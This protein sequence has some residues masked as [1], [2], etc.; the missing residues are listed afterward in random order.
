[1]AYWDVSRGWRLRAALGAAGSRTACEA[2]ASSRG[3][4]DA[5]TRAGSDA[6]ARA[7]ALLAGPAADARLLAGPAADARA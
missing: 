1:M 5:D 3:G 6:D 2:L 7:N 4:P